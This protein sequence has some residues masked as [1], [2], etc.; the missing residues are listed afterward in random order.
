MAY[1]A[2]ELITD[3]FHLSG[4]VARDFQTPTGSQ[5]TEGL[6]LLNFALAGKRSQE[7]LI[8]YFS[9][10]NFDAVAGQEKYFIPNL[11]LIETFTFNIDTV[12]YP[13]RKDKRGTYFA[14][15]RVENIQT[16]PYSWHA[17]RTKGGS[18]LY[19][20]FEPDQNYPMTIWGKFALDAVDTL[21]DDLELVY[22]RD[23]LDYL[24][25]KL[26]DYLCMDYGISVTPRIK[27]QL[28]AL[29]NILTDDSPL[30]LQMKKRST[31]SGGSHLN[32]AI[33]N[34][35]RGLWPS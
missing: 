26:A 12:R 25:F 32:Y 19:V 3:A 34:L 16:L 5:I 9:E 7:R 31:L 24:R 23:Y 14:T 1:T 10:Y 2:R 35:Y 18:D 22:D 11:A 28:D 15:A 21:D 30:D 17:E 8:P 33:V 29:E 6:K 20:Y 4:I 27:Q 13:T